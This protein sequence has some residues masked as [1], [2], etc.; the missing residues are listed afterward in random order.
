MKHDGGFSQRDET[1]EDLSDNYY[2]LS[3]D[4]ATMLYDAGLDAA[5][6]LEEAD[7]VVADAIDDYLTYDPRH[8]ES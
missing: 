8:L 2:Q 6:Y 4:A 5:G 3:G 7:A 1:L